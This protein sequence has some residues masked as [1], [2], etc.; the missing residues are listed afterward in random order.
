MS[1]AA[2]NRRMAALENSAPVIDDLA[3]YV[4]WRAHGCPSG[5]RWDPTFKE[6]I[7]AALA[8]MKGG[9]A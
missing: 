3:D 4:L 7:E 1:V 5:V 6:K 2:L 8:K 9:A